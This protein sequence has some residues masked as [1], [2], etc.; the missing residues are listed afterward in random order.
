MFAGS[1]GG[2][3]AEGAPP[4]LALQPSLLPDALSPLMLLSPQ[5]YSLLGGAG[6]AGS[7]CSFALAFSRSL[8]SR[9]VVS[10]Y[11]G[12]TPRVSVII[13]KTDPSCFLMATLRFLE[14]CIAGN[15]K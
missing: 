12:A 8:S 7:V 3:E 6:L 15:P 1:I 2:A 4:C 11:E 9:W 5:C 13:T 14:L 10:G